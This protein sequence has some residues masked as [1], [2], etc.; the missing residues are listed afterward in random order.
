MTQPRKNTHPEDLKAAIRKSGKTMEG[1]SV[2]L[3]YAPC[4]VGFAIRRR[5]HEV[6]VGIAELLGQSLRDLWPEDYHPDN[7]PRRH[8]PRSKSSRAAR[9]SRRTKSAEELTV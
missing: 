1:L 2:D 4:A 7:T 3:G 9:L 5:W 8:R 6:R